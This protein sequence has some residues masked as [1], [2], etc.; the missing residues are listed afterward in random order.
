[1]TATIESNRAINATT[2]H[3][4]QLINFY[5]NTAHHMQRRSFDESEYDTVT[6]QS[7]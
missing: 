1:M 2:L 3:R 4:Q 6:E 7:P 5:G